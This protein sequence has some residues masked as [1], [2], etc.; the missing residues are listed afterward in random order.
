MNVRAFVALVMLLPLCGCWPYYVRIPDPNDTNFAS[1]YVSWRREKNALAACKNLL[2]KDEALMAL[3]SP[4]AKDRMTDGELWTYRWTAQ[5]ATATTSDWVP[6]VGY[7]TTVQ[8]DLDVMI[9][10]LKFDAKGILRD[11]KTDGDYIFKEARS[12]LQKLAPAARSSVGVPLSAEALAAPDAD[13]SGTWK[14]VSGRTGEVQI[15]QQGKLIGWRYTSDKG[16]LWTFGGRV[17]GRT[18]TGNYILP[19]YRGSHGRWEAE[20]SSDGRQITLRRSYLNNYNWI[21]VW[22]LA[23]TSASTQ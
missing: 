5:T 21:G 12:P 8:T 10:K 11:W 19:S 1:K 22:R 4:A 23:R 18:A 14:I 9:V 16:F 13:F 6:F 17:K 20:L 7:R 3:G 15:E 2:T